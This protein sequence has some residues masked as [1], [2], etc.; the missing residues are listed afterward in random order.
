MTDDKKWPER[1][2]TVL[3]SWAR[4]GLMTYVGL[5]EGV[6]RDGIAELEAKGTE[7]DS[8]AEKLGWYMCRHEKLKTENEKLREAL[9]DARSGAWIEYW[10]KSASKFDLLFCAKCAKEA[11]EDE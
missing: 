10:E 5:L 8:I 3:G 9:R 2:G 7:L 4:Y 6:I 11:L 1:A